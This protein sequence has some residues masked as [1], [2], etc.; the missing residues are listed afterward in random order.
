MDH[1]SVHWRHSVSCSGSRSRGAR[2]QSLNCFGLR[3]RR[4]GRLRPWVLRHTANDV[5]GLNT[6]VQPDKGRA[7]GVL[8]REL[9]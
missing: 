1:Y 3:D 8:R 7:I 5:A 4:D 9:Y 2:L 6:P